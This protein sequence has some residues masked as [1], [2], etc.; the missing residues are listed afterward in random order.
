MSSARSGLVCVVGSLNDDT[1]L[2]VEA[3]PAPGETTLTTGPRLS[4][5]GGKGANQAAAA[6]VLGADLGCRVAMVG[7]VGD[8]EPGERSL[9]ALTAAGVDVSRVAR[10]ADDGTGI[11]VITVDAAGE[12]TI[13]V[14]AGAND[15]VAAEEAASAVADLAPAVVVLQLEVPVPAVAAAAR[16]ATGGGLVVLNPAPMPA[17]AGGVRELLGAVDVLVPNRGELGR[18]AGRPEPTSAAEVTDCVAALDFAGSVVVTLGADGALCFEKGVERG[19]DPVAVDGERV[20]TVDASGAGDVFCGCLAAG[21]AAGEP[22]V[23]AVRRANAAAAASTTH[24]G[25]RLTV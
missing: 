10:R 23:D 18:L 19:A 21:L 25:A 6:A 8:D 4:S 24:H 12:N 17:D 13:V 7:A 5:P 1:T 22:L 20:D 2:R 3:L 14:D 11:A 15:T 16:A 9:A